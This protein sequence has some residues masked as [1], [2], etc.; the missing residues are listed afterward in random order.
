MPLTKQK[1][2]MVSKA[3]YK[4]WVKKLPPNDAYIHLNAIESINFQ[5][6][7]QDQNKGENGSYSPL[8]S[9][10]TTTSHITYIYI[11][12]CYIP[13]C[14]INFCHSGLLSNKLTKVRGESV[15]IGPMSKI[16]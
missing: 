9:K 8:F 10:L 11:Y 3:Y 4:C 6:Q 12:I 14:V 15:T 13:K 5:L 16:T 1:A 7:K 2:S